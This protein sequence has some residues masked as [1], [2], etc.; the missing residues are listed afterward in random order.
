MFENELRFFEV[1]VLIE[2]KP[3]TL[4]T[5]SVQQHHPAQEPKGPFLPPIK[6]VPKLCPVQTITLL[7]AYV[8]S[9]LIVHII[10]IKVLFQM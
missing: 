2:G 6:C 3:A 9:E 8:S 10:V 7:L 1:Q 5:T 4:L